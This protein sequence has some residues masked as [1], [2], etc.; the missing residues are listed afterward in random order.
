MQDDWQTYWRRDLGMSSITR[1]R[2]A[3]T[4]RA[5]NSYRKVGETIT[6]LSITVM[7]SRMRILELAIG[8]LLMLFKRYFAMKQTHDREIGAM[9]NNVLVVAFVHAGAMVSYRGADFS[10]EIDRVKILKRLQ[11]NETR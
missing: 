6:Y 4:L 2:D 11:Q 3:P 5:L 10:K 9:T 1:K 7:A 8:S